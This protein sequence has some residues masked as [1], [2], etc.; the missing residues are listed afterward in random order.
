VPSEQRGEN[1]LGACRGGVVREHEINGVCVGAVIA[2]HHVKLG[3]GDDAFIPI[4]WLPR[5][6]VREG[7][8]RK[9][10]TVDI[11]TFIKGKIRAQAVHRVFA[12]EKMVNVRVVGAGIADTVAAWP[13][14]LTIPATIDICGGL[15]E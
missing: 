9:G 13:D 2:D 15:R 7:F 8:W 5:I 4:Q 11:G 12:G 10:V 1:S 14:V 3:T 6:A